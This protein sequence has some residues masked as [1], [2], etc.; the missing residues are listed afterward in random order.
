MALVN[1]I[2]VEVLNNPA[3]F[4]E[5]FQFRIEFECVQQL[6]ADLEWKVIYVASA[7]DHSQVQVLEEVDVG[8]VQVGPN[9]FQLPV[10]PPNMDQISNT[11]LIG[12]TVLLLTC[13]YLNHEFIRIG[14]YVN[15]EY[16]IEHDPENIQNLQ[17]DRNYLYHDILA[18]EPGVTRIPIDWSGEQG[19]NIL[20]DQASEAEASA[21]K[22]GRDL[23]RRKQKRSLEEE[24]DDQLIDGCLRA[25]AEP[26]PISAGE[27][28]GDTDAADAPNVTKIP[29]DCSMEEEEE[30]LFL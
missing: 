10:N 11:D 23:L 21:G 22:W 12:V 3:I 4:S 29:I 24:E 19:Q 13:S 7:E 15:N 9:Q 28:Q 26:L 5:P 16:R 14:Y 20:P 1:I 8:P 2:N 27:W 30:D 25:T 17:I 6:Q 18:D